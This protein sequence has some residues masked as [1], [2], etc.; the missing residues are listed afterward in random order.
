MHDLE[1][2]AGGEVSFASLREPAWHGLG[3]VFDSPLSTKEMLDAAHLSNWNIRLAEIPQDEYNYTQKAYFVIR[4]NPFASN[5]GKPCDVL[6]IVGNR[7]QVLQ[8]EDLF[9][10][11]D[12][13][14]DGGGIWE[15]AGSI[16]NGRVVF[17]SMS[18]DREIVLDPNGVADAVNTYLLVHTS[19]DG[20]VSVQATVTP[21]RVVCQNTLNLALRQT[22]NSF[23]IRHTQTISGKID[24]ARR[25]LNLFHT[26]VDEFSNLAKSLYEFS[27]ND[28]VFNDI[29]NAAYPKPENDKKG[30]MTKWSNKIDTICDIYNGSTTVGIRNTGWGALNAMTERLDWYRNGRTDNG[31]SILA[32]SSGF[33]ATT[34][35]E[36]NRLQRLVSSYAS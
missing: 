12:N 6:G 35:S 1:V 34:N 11:A 8:N 29:I 14:L 15:T 24:E 5:T 25:T 20:S 3:T 27:I 4:D 9:S 32:A 28:L 33:D 18:M 19:H 30:S 26:Y 7:Y 22:A 17:G 31:E 21:V 23:K 16:R 13:I 2:G 36:K 10:F